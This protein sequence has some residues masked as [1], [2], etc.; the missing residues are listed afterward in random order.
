MKS[1]GIIFLVTLTFSLSG[2]KYDWKRGLLRGSTFAVAGVSAGLHESI[3]HRYTGFK[4]VFPNADDRF[5]NPKESWQRKYEKP[6]PLAETFPVFT[7][8]YHL[9]N[10]VRTVGLI[11]STTFI[12]IGEKRPWWHYAVDLGI[13]CVFYGIGSNATYQ[14]FTFRSKK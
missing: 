3:Q 6:Y 4:A 11:G 14:Y 7:D 10:A 12:V 9:T 5:W 2:Q 8:A 1:I 13:G